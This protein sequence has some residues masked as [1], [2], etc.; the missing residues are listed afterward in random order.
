[1]LLL[2]IT[3]CAVP[4]N[5]SGSLE[6]QLAICIAPALQVLA[7]V[8]ELESWHPIKFMLPAEL[9]ANNAF[10]APTN[11]KHWLRLID[12]PALEDVKLMAV[13]LELTT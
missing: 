1:M 13:L 12:D 7:V 10:V 8:D 11:V 6:K 5:D 4:E 3:N 2:N 9:E